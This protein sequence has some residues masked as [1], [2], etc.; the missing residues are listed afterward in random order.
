MERRRGGEET[1]EV[2]RMKKWEEKKKR[3]EKPRGKD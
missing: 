3:K 2:S 1:R